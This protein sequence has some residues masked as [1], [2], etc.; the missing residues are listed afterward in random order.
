MKNKILLTFN[1]TY[2]GHALIKVCGI[3]V[4][5]LLMLVTIVG[6]SINTMVDIIKPDTTLEGTMDQFKLGSYTNHTT[7]MI[8]TITDVEGLEF[9]GKL[10]YLSTGTSGKIRGIIY[11]SSNKIWFTP[12]ERTKDSK[13]YTLLTDIPYYAELKDGILSGYWNYANGEMGG[14]FSIPIPTETSASSSSLAQTASSSDQP[15]QSSASINLH[16]EKTNVTIGEN[17]LLKLSAVNLIT[18]PEMHVQIVL[19]PPSG[20][21]VSSSEF[22]DSGAGQYTAKFDLDPG[23]GKD[24]E[25][26]IA[27]NQVGSFDVKGRVIYYFGENKNDGEDYLLSLPIQVLDTQPISTPAPEPEPKTTMLGIGS[28]GLVL[29]LIMSSL[30]RRK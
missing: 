3:T 26:R 28:T 10:H 29:I 21:S 22:V 4:I 19:I 17:I 5:S 14:T 24:I 11:P 30:V 13:G 20:M 7:P 1:K 15:T 8:I 27:A 18:K 12:Y 6:A 16:G 25:V 2:K 23:D 9:N